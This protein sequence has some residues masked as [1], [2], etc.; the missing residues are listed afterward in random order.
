MGWQPMLGTTNTEWTGRPQGKKTGRK[1]LK[2]K[3][4][5]STHPSTAAHTQLGLWSDHQSLNSQ[6]WWIIRVSL[7]QYYWQLTAGAFV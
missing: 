1:L 7:Y 6:L 3:S 2:D 5:G 4:T